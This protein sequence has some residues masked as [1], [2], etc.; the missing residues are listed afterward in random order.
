M[1]NPSPVDPT[2]DTTSANGLSDWLSAARP[3]GN[4]PYGIE[5][6]AASRTHQRPATSSGSHTRRTH[7]EVLARRHPAIGERDQHAAAG[8]EQRLEDGQGEPRHGPEVER[9]PGD[10]L[11]VERE[12]EREA[13]QQRPTTSSVRSG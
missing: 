2:Q 8:D 10:L 11:Q 7:R 1:T 3:H 4:P 13:D 9:G 6:V 12:A 5:P